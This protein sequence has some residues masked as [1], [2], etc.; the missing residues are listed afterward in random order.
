MAAS[1]D[2]VQEFA[3]LIE[4]GYK[5]YSI[6]GKPSN[7]NQNF[8]P[9]HGVS[10]RKFVLILNEVLRN[11]DI[12]PVQEWGGMFVKPKR[13]KV[14]LQEAVLHSVRETY[15]CHEDFVRLGMNP[16]KNP[17]NFYSTVFHNISKSENNRIW[18]NAM[19]AFLVCVYGLFLSNCTLSEFIVPQTCLTYDNFCLHQS[20][21]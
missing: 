8:V 5:V 15:G 1:T 21:R 17:T 14:P 9:P 2:I 19:Q 20:G 4:T 3:G 13:G 16:T 10:P 6:A 7:L 11:R 12:A 18:M